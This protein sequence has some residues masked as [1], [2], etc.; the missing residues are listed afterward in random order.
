MKHTFL[1]LMALISLSSHA[2]LMSSDPT[3]EPSN[4]PN[5]NWNTLYLSNSQHEEFRSLNMLQS[6][7]AS[8]PSSGEKLYISSLLYQ[9]M[10][11][12]N[13]PYYG[14]NSDDKNY[15]VTEETFIEALKLDARGQYKEAQELFI[16]VSDTMQQ[17]NDSVGKAIIKY[18]LCRSLNE[19][20]KYHQAHY[21]CSALQSYFE[22]NTDPVLQIFLGYRVIA[23]NQYFRGDY[24]SA[25]NSYMLL[26]DN[27]PKGH[28]IS[29][30]YN[31]IGNL[32]KE[33]EQFDSSETYLLTA[34][35]LRADSSNLMKTQVLHSLA[36]LYIIMEQ[37]TQAI[38]Y[39]Q[40]AYNAV[41]A[42]NSIYGKA[43]VNLGLGKAHIQAE[44]YSSAHDYLVEALTASEKL[45]NNKIRIEAYLAISDLFE[46]QDL[47]EESFYYAHLASDL[48][49]QIDRSKYLADSLLQLTDL[50]VATNQHKEAFSFYR[51]YSAIQLSSRDI[52]NRLALE[53]LELTRS[54]F[55]KELQSSLLVSQAQL[56]KLKIDK[57]TQQKL[58]Y[59]IIV[60]ILLCAASFSF[61]SSKRVREKSSLDSLTSAYN[62]AA[63]IRKIKTV[64]HDSNN[65]KHVLILLDLDKFKS[66]N[67]DYGHPTGDQALSNISQQIR[68][69]I[70]KHD[71]LGRL[72]GEEFV[73]LL[74]DVEE[75]EV[76]ERV[77][78][79]QYAVSSTKFLSE[80]K[81]PLSITASFSYLSTSQALSDFDVLYSV[82]DQALYQAKKNGRNCIIDAYNDAIDLPS[83]VFEPVQ[84]SL[85]SDSQGNP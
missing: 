34:L 40:Q 58:M 42:T 15:K 76:R 49:K 64:K 77:E 84:T 10:I 43:L 12:H 16:S 82:L 60:I 67:D 2:N 14:G 17:A 8:L 9:F 73:I 6:R 22:D 37:P 39:F 19:Q 66:I 7:Y 83:S 72:G 41:Q 61:W 81:K 70:G 50:S 78:E 69:R 18:N 59:N 44:N 24:K 31:D 48:S 57:M 35:D 26:I 36:E 51:Q 32:Y 33:I 79:I 46:H 62:R 30:I 27:F 65:K 11:K 25:L 21:Y 13:Q 75:S 23:N 5:I 55:E 52:D 3:K 53:A 29:G 56:D 45:D 20:S 4:T 74:K 63:A 28:D 1:I 54:K 80:S 38:S 47:F 85:Q 68:N 71:L